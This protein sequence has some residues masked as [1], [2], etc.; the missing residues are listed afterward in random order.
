MPVDSTEPDFEAEIYA[1]PTEDGG[2]RTPMQSGYRPNHN[3]GLPEELNDAQHE[4]PHGGK[5]APGETGVALLRL[6]APKRQ[7][8][9]LFENMEFTVQEGGRIVGRGRITKVLKDE[10]KRP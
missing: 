5:L 9:R 1:L 10:L 2:R 3:F 7:H 8:K 4:Y 6:L